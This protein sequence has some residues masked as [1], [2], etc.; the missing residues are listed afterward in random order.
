MAFVPSGAGNKAKLAA[1]AVQLFDADKLC[2]PR[3]RD[4]AHGIIEQ[5]FQVGAGQ[6]SMA[7]LG[8]CRL[9]A[10]PDLQ[11]ELGLLGDGHIGLDAEVIVHAPIVAAHWIEAQLVPDRATAVCK[12]GQNSARQFLPFDVFK[13]LLERAAIFAVLK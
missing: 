3:R 11:F 7:Q 10:H 13:Q 8:N 1:V 5:F 2:V 12:A 4:H 6:R 9:L